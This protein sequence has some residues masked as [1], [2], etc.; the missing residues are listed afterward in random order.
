MSGAITSER[1]QMPLTDVIVAII[2]KQL[3]I[4]YNINMLHSKMNETTL[5]ELFYGGKH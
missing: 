5:S 2:C 1:N 3:S 4:I